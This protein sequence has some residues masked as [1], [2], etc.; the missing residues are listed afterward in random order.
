MILKIKCDGFT[1]TFEISTELNSDC[2]TFST[3]GCFT[4]QSL[5]SNATT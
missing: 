3:H 2:G 4:V 5:N 1:V